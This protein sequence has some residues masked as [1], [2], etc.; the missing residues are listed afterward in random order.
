VHHLLNFAR[1]GDDL[2]RGLT[3]AWSR[4]GRGTPRASPVTGRLP[5]SPRALIARLGLITTCVTVLV[6]PLAYA[7]LATFQLAQRASE[8]AA[9]GA[10]HIE[11]QLP[12][13]QASDWLNQVSIDALHAIRT[14]NSIVVASW[15]TDK[16]N[17]TLMFQGETA[18][19]PEIKAK[20]PIR[21]A[22]FEGFLNI[23]V[24]S[25]QVFIATFY[26]AAAFAI[27][28]LAAFYGFRRVPLAALDDAQVLLQAK[29][30]ELIRKKSQLETQNLRFDAALNNM[31]QGLCMFDAEHKLVVCN[32]PYVR[33]YKLAD[34]LAKPGVSLREILE[35]RVAAGTYP[36]G[37]PEEYCREV[38]ERAEQD[39]PTTRISELADGRIIVVKHQPMRGGGWV[40]THEDITEYRRIEA[41]MAHMARHDELTELPNRVLLRERLGRALDEAQK[42]KGLAVICLDL[43]RFKE[44]ND[45]LGH[46]VGDALLQAVAERLRRCV[47][48]SDTV[49]RLGGDEFAVLQMATEQPVAA[50]A[51][52]TR[53]CE[54][55]TEPFDLGAHQL[56][57][58]ASLGIAVAPGDGADPDQLLKNADLALHRAKS[59]G[60]G[61]YR[62]FEHDM[63]A[64][65]QA[66]R[67]LE[68]DLR[69]ALGNGEF[70]LYY[71]PLVNLERNEIACMEALLRW[72]H[73]ERG[74]VSP[75]EFI[76][77]AE[78][79]GLIVPIGEWVLRQ[80]CATAVGWPDHIKVA[81]NL[82]AIQFKSRHLVETVFPA[83]AASGLPAERLE[84]EITESVLLQNNETT[85]AMLHQLRA[86]GVRIA[87][88]DFGTGY[89][90]LS[91]L[92]SFPFDKIKIDRCFVTDIANASA[93]EE[94]LAILR[95]VA[96]LGSSLGI[97]TTAE[98]VETKEQLD[99]VRAEGCTE[100]Q[101]YFFSPPRPIGDLAKLFAKPLRGAS[102][103]A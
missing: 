87:L 27:L 22:N 40:A 46:P 93:G 23:A 30:G 33:I 103:A 69:K 4:L 3:A 88:D 19:W 85:L 10:R 24:S 54:A 5:T 56:S 50:T 99:R 36:G 1:I 17:A 31:S 35:H 42:G 58:G 48:E 47:G 86:L 81:I 9:L 60:R 76:P 91:Y 49:A 98:G 102:D 64:H 92:R 94:P 41:R 73:P 57:A 72:H 43:D 78:E 53:I 84:L 25:R 80:A 16:N 66:R 37:S 39:R 83:L 20:M 75:A 12:K 90:S 61:I 71:Q 34:E 21:A 8:Q 29:Q 101:G 67:K 18:W 96:G 13:Q 11:V 79:T 51:L 28:G 100:M 38:L 95:A 32:A 70:E 82:S 97:A 89:S 55:L 65:M 62:F 7:A 45:T 6:P 63:D 15:I 77:L 74:R 26:I 44:V 59:E 14:H 52:A 68:L 2:R